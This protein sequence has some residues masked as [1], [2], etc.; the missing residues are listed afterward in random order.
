MK[1]IRDASRV[2]QVMEKFSVFP[3]EFR[4]LLYARTGWCAPTV[5][6]LLR[7]RS[8]TAGIQIGPDPISNPPDTSTI[9]RL[10]GGGG[11]DAGIKSAALPAPHPDGLSSG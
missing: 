3:N 7:A 6:N 5:R 11:G 9:W 1:D 8:P 4:S 2:R 10:G